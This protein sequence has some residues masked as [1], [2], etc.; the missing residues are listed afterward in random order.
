MLMFALLT[1]AINLL[2]V[3]CIAAAPLLPAK[4]RV[5]SAG[6]FW[7][8]SVLGIGLAVTLAESGKH[9]SVWPGRP[10]FPSGH[11]TLALA[12][13]TCLA[14][15]NPRWLALALPLAAV[16]AWALVAG[17]F[18]RPVDVAGALATGIL[19]PLACFSVKAGGRQAD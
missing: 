8:R 10:T 19:P 11:E 15:Q 9:F 16:Q 6:Q 13:G 17:H 1:N 12:A 2:L 5:Q 18:H 3:F 7:L 14:L 4:K